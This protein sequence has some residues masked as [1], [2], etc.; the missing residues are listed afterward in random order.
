MV[1]TRTR[2][3]LKPPP[4]RRTGV[5]PAPRP[6]LPPPPERVWAPVPDPTPGAKETIYLPFP[7]P[8]DAAALAEAARY[9]ATLETNRQIA[10]EPGTAAPGTTHAIERDAQGRRRLVRRRFSL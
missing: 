7:S 2:A 1:T 10:R 5:N 4:K 6:T 9:V 8:P 3:K